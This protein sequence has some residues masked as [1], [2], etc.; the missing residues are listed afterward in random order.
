MSGYEAL[1]ARRS[2]RKFKSEP[3]PEDVVQ[4]I[5]TAGMVAPSA[6]NF[7]PWEFIVVRCRDKLAELSRVCKYWRFL[8]EA[9][10]AVVVLANLS[11]RI[12]DLEGFFPQDCG[13]CTENLLIAATGEGLGSCWLGC[14][15]VRENM[16]GVRKAL[17]VPG[18]VIPFSLVALGVSDS[19]RRPRTTFLAEKVHFDKY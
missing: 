5:L 14:Y 13:A 9:G 4:R 19:N 3:V 2:I 1:L 11:S 17:G 8:D 7:Q 12:P 18:S 16:D 15:P 10:L 6:H